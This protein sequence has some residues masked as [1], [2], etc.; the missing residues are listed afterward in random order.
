MNLYVIPSKQTQNIQS[1][2][3]K[4]KKNQLLE[5]NLNYISLKKI[6]TRKQAYG[7]SLTLRIIRA[8]KVQQVKAHTC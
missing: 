1:N 4:T 7:K 6:Y 8:S 3:L 5:N 2:K